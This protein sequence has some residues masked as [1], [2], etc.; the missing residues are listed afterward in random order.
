MP[1]QHLRLFSWQKQ[2]KKYKYNKYNKNQQ[3]NK[4]KLHYTRFFTLTYDKNS[5]TF[6]GKILLNN[7]LSEFTS[8]KS[9]L[10]KSMEIWLGASFTKQGKLARE[11]NSKKVP[12]GVEIY[13][14]DLPTIKEHS[15]NISFTYR[16]TQ[17]TK[18]SAN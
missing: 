18:H 10:W 9:F 14:G 11:R 17:Y 16:P 2:L 7:S 8:E 12:M 15:R 4:H 3:T 6:S 1:H 5:K 13:A